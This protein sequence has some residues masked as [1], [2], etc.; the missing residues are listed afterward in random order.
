MFLYENNCL[1]ST[2]LQDQ[3]SLKTLAHP[4]LRSAGHNYSQQNTHHSAKVD[5]TFM[6][7]ITDAT[8]GSNKTLD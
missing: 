5:L 3:S 2:N 7:H 4:N 1:N 8:K 6:I